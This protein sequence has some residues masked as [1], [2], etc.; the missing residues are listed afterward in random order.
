M[1]VLVSGAHG[2]V[3]SALCAAL[4]E[5]GDEAVALTRGSEPGTFDEAALTAGRYDAVVHLAGEPLLG[6][7]TDDKRAAIRDSRVLGTTMVARTLAGL[8]EAQRPGALLVASAVGY[9]GDRGE[10]LVTEQSAA[11]DTFLSSVVSEWEA[12]AQPAR[13]AGIR[14]AHLRMAAVQS[15]EG[16]ALKEQ[17]LPFRLGLGGRVGSGRQWMPWIGL[18]EA[19]R[20]WLLA[21]D[22]ERVEGPVNVVGP[23]PAR[24]AQYVKAL[25]RVLHRPTLLPVPLPIL[26]ARYSSQ[27]VD[28]MLLH[29]QKVVPAKLEAL[30][31]EFE[32]RTVEQALRHE[33]GA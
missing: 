19:I 8:D 33:L 13:D 18:H 22:D 3:G 15:R 24:N 5:R 14:T 28:E 27:L 25:G 9:Y 32:D 10:E 11:G 17:L 30:G 20:V 23:T 21:I 7:W 1:R 2:L 31:F 4:E 12:A 29:G 26:R 6:R 16:G